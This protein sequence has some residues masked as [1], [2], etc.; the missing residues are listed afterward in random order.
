MVYGDFKDLN[1]RKV[2]DRYFVIKHS[3]LVKFQDMMDIKMEMVQWSIKN[4]K[5]NIQK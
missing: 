1:R 2:A 5:W 4:F 3:T